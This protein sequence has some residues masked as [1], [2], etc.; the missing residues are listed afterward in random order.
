MAPR[1]KEDD[2]SDYHHRY[3]DYYVSVSVGPFE[4]GDHSSLPFLKRRSQ[5]SERGFTR[6]FDTSE[7]TYLK[8][9]HS[10]PPHR[11]PRPSRVSDLKPWGLYPQQL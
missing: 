8:L 9:D 1:V 3:D 10:I 5:L 11:A 4:H 7:R 6:S 2:H